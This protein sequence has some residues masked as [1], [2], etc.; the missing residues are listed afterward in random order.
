MA[1][2]VKLSQSGNLPQQQDTLSPEELKKTQD[3][4]RKQMRE[5][6]DK[7]MEVSDEEAT[8]E[9]VEALKKEFEEAVA[10]Y[11]NQMF[12][13]HEADETAIEY[14]KFIKEW[15]A[16]YNH[17]VNGEWKG[18]IALNKM[19]DTTI[20][21]M[22]DAETKPVA[23]DVD[24]STLIYLYNNMG[25]PQGTGLEEALAMAK[26]ENYDIEKN[27]I[28]DNNNFVTYSNI[29]QSLDNHIK[30]LRNVDKK[31]KLMRE[32]VTMALAGIKISWKITELEEFIELH[33]AWLAEAVDND[34]Q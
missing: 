33:D 32:R 4:I 6:F 21:Q 12:T 14:P 16:K 23:F 13:V 1:K 20:K 11:Q 28:F 27:E 17:W 29:I 34:M 5:K 31:L 22:E 25:K 3:T 30:M 18:V 8:K 19:M 9:D 10:S 15:N 2:K 24:Y 7:W 26:M